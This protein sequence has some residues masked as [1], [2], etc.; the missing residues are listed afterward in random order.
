[1]TIETNANITSAVRKS[2][3]PEGL[4]ESVNFTASITSI[5]SESP[6]I[7]GIN[8]TEISVKNIEVRVREDVEKDISITVTRIPEEPPEDIPNITGIVY[9]YMEIEHENLGNEE[10]ENA[11]IVF[12]VRKIW[13]TG[14]SI[15][16]SDIYL[17]RYTDKW[18]KLPTEFLNETGNVYYYRAATPGLSMFAIFSEKIMVSMNVECV[19]LDVKCE[20]NAVFEC[21]LEGL[22]QPKKICSYACRDGECIQEDEPAPETGGKTV[23]NPWEAYNLVM[24]FVAVII[25]VSLLGAYLKFRHKRVM[26]ELPGV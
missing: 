19:P 4:E 3:N 20:E 12:E 26:A 1:M 6:A 7:I 16:K 10:I 18:D 22:W 24:L 9:Q 8:K 5:T 2:W 17:A 14:N 25:V 13:V 21:S 23:L 11:S 15:N